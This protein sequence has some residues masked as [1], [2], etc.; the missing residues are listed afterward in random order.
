MRPS[1]FASILLV[2]STAMVVTADDDLVKRHY[3]AL[4]DSV[5]FGFIVQAGWE[6]RN[7]W[8]FFVLGCTRQRLSEFSKRRS[9]PT[10]AST[11][12]FLPCHHDSTGLRDLLS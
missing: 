2:L 9:T 5:T 1:P 4:G 7:H 11:S 10:G 8:Q 12:C 6:W 3:L